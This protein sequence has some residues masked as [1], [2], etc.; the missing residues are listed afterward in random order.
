MPTKELSATKAV[1][2]FGRRMRMLN[3]SVASIL[4]LAMMWHPAIALCQ[5]AGESVKVE[6]NKARG[7]GISI[8][9]TRVVAQGTPQ[10]PISEISFVYKVDNRKTIFIVG[11]GTVPS[12]GQFTFLTQSTQLTIR[13]SIDGET[14]AAVPI[15]TTFVIAGDTNETMPTATAFSSFG[16]NG[17]WKGVGFRF[18]S[19]LDQVLNSANIRY[20]YC[21]EQ[22]QCVIT[23]YKTVDFPALHGEKGKVAIK[24]TFDGLEDGAKFRV[25][26]TVRKKLSHGSWLET[27][28]A[29][30]VT[31][32]TE[33]VKNLVR[34]L[35]KST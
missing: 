2:F 20:A 31:A 32:A 34:M 25:Y 13:E 18:K 9:V 33:F 22:E 11:P 28:D 5:M 12:E 19:H 17:H 29:A 8:E 24:V 35:E 14:I 16:Q 26:M 30:V 23:V 3:S 10:H 1:I 21:S 4:A 6:P 7:P 15:R 27:D